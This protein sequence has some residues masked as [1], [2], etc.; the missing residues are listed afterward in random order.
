MASHHQEAL[1]QFDEE[2]V[3]AAGDGSSSHVDA[4]GLGRVQP[5][6]KP[7]AVSPD[8]VV[9]L[10]GAQAFHA[11]FQIRFWITMRGWSGEV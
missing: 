1:D 4:E 10:N 3:M 2:A 6:D 7:V 9:T 11:P 8:Q 5:A